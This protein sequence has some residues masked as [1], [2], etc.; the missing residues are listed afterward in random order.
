MQLVAADYIIT[1]HMYMLYVF[2]I[3]NIGTTIFLIDLLILRETDLTLTIQRSQTEI[4][5]PN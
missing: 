1:R 4:R 5:V 2:S 3:R